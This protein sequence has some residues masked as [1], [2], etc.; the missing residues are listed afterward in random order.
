MDF[1]LCPIY[2]W[3]KNSNANNKLGRNENHEK[4]YGSAIQKQKIV[5]VLKQAETSD[6][7]S[8]L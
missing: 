7:C 3:T 2:V 1:I 4:T 6:F 8:C 5:M